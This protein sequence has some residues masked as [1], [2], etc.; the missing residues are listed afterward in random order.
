MLIEISRF[1]FDFSHEGIVFL[2]FTIHIRIQLIEMHR[3]MYTK[4]K[5]KSARI[6]RL[7]NLISTIDVNALFH[8]WIQRSVNGHFTRFCS[9]LFTDIK[10]SKHIDENFH[11]LSFDARYTTIK[12]RSYID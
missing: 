7:P 11:Q 12:C 3:T 10:R 2:V 9:Y 4:R 6:L 8:I 1:F 5:K